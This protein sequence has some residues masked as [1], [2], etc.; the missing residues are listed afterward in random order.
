MDVHNFVTQ[1]GDLHVCGPLSF[2][3]GVILKFAAAFPQ[4]A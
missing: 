3:S 1:Q 4:H 2:D